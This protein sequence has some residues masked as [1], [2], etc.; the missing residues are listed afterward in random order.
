MPVSTPYTYDEDLDV[1]RFDLSEETRLRE[2][3]IQGVYSALSN[4]DIASN[5]TVQSIQNTIAT[6]QQNI[7][8][9]QN[10]Y[11]TKAEAEADHA[12]LAQ[13]IAAIVIPPAADLTPYAEKTELAALQQSVNALPTVSHLDE[14]RAL[15]P[16]VVDFVKQSDIDTS[17]S[18][19]TVDYLP[20]TGGE[21]SGSFEFNKTSY[22]LPALDFSK[23]PVTSHNAFKFQSL[24]PTAGNYSTFGST[25]RFWEQAWKFASDEDFCWIYNDSNKVFS[26]TKEGPACS[27]LYIGDFSPNGDNGRVIH[28]KI[29]VRDRLTAY[30][31]AF[32]QIRE[33][34]SSSTDFDSL[35][36]GLLTALAN[37]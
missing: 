11:I 19:I 29:D 10:T 25:Q 30:Q 27:Q 5:G 23:T 12:E 2:R 37:V 36:A 24:A 28:N 17:I 9:L 8:A 4:L 15:I 32:Q 22:D 1:I 3:E 20:R 18:N 14:V 26:I 31:S 16:S 35:K 7:T 21:L 13:Q 33:A 34:V 6:A